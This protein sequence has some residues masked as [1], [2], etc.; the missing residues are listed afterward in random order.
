ML[1][2]RL[3]KSFIQMQTCTRWWQGEEAHARAQ[4]LEKEKEQAEFRAREI[5]REKQ[6]AQADLAA[7]KAAGT[8][9]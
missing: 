9:G 8:C 2:V 5:E 6:A 4:L 7:A 1:Y 3:A